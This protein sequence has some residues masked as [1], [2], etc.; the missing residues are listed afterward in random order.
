MNFDQ[1]H[2][3]Q[4]AERRDWRA[5]NSHRS[6]LI[7]CCLLP[8]L[9]LFSCKAGQLFKAQEWSENYALLDGVT[10]TSPEMVD[11]DLNTVGES[12]REILITLPER[13]SIHRIVLRGIN[14]TDFIIYGGRIG[15]GNWQKL[16][17]VNNNR[18]DNLELRVTTATDRIR[19][20]I[21]GTSDDQRVAGRITPLTGRVVPQRRWARKRAAE[22][23]LYGFKR[24]PPEDS[25]A[26]KDSLD[27]ELSDE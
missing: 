17:T 18:A 14:F 8:G 13:K 15:E 3:R 24:T 7:I 25:S 10:C 5:A 20:R 27:E 1:E 9:F 2:N 22:I 12:G 6:L 16:K 11:G 19:F 23:E 21:G 4:P 26:K